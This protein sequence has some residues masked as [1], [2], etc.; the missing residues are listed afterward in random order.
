MGIEKERILLLVWFL[1]CY[2]L[3]MWQ[4]TE[5]TVTVFRERERDMNMKNK[6]RD[7]KGG[8]NRN[9]EE[10]WLERE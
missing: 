8:G 4:R 5:T 6:T 1:W 3:K 10:V 2:S 7:R 9:R